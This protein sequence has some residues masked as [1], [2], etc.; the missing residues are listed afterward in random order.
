MKLYVKNMVCQRC[1]MAVEGEL[2][3]LGIE[4]TDVNLREI[5]TKSELGRHQL[6]KLQQGLHAL[7]FE[8]IDDRKSR[9]IEKIK[10]NV[11]QVVHHQHEQKLKL[12]ELL[13][14]ELHLDYPY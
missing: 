13:V 7:G 14:N 1:I 3:K 11:I 10:N 4:A 9:M 12:S 2:N 8:L 6:D 5:T